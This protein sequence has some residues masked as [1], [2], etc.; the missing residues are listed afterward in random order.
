MFGPRF[1]SR[2]PR[3]PASVAGL[4]TFKE[5]AGN[6]SGNDYTTTTV[7]RVR[8][9]TGMTVALI[10]MTH[11]NVDFDGAP[12]AY[13]PPSFDTLDSLADGGKDEA[14]GYYGLMAVNPTEVW[15]VVNKK[16]ILVKDHFQLDLETDVTLADAHGRLPVKQKTGPFKGFYVSTTARTDPNG[17]NSLYEQSHYLDSSAVAFYA[18]SYGISQEGIGD[19]D[20]G[21]ALRLDNFKTASFA[22]MGSEGHGKYSA[23]A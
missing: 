5:A 19:Q 11:M 22:C 18:T 2:Q 16:P 1:S 12:N 9:G 4:M 23:K 15:A 3:K 7:T 20:F 10:F 8:D 13:G 21:V 14:K 6:W 17:S